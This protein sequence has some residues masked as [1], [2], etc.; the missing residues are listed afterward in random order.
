[1][2]VQ[3]N[4][5][6]EKSLVGDVPTLEHGQQS[7]NLAYSLLG[8]RLVTFFSC[9]AKWCEYKKI[10][11]FGSFTHVKCRCIESPLAFINEIK[12]EPTWIIIVDPTIR[13]ENAKTQSIEHD[14]A[15]RFA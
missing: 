10:H 4:N 8:K 15:W 14:T 11:P 13:D 2:G 1:M 9:D 3:F 6:L 7:H 5:V 12:V